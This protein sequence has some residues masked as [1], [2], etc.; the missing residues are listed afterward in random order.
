MKNRLESVDEKDKIKFIG[1]LAIIFIHIS[2]FMATVNFLIIY[3]GRFNIDSN[4]TITK[5][6]LLH[7]F[8]AT[9]LPLFALALFSSVILKYCP[10]SKEFDW[11]QLT[12]SK[13]EN[14]KDVSVKNKTDT[15][16]KQEI[17]NVAKC[18][19]YGAII[20]AFILLFCSVFLFLP[21]SAVNRH[22]ITMTVRDSV[23]IVDIKTLLNTT[24]T[25]EDEWIFSPSNKTLTN[26][27]ANI[28][29]D[30]DS[31]QFPH[32]VPGKIG[33]DDVIPAY[34]VPVPLGEVQIIDW[35]KKPFRYI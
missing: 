8:T 19:L 2:M 25:S 20:I 24:W 14:P 12:L 26:V 35:K 18:I 15:V 33:G 29:L 22:F 23:Q 28:S 4:N 34:L 7:I 17:R 16:T 1:T 21:K 3:Y 10:I 27:K 9:L 31:V 5:Q 30:E 11:T 6:Q 32:P 13:Q